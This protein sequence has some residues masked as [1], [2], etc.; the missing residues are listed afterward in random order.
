MARTY[1]IDIVFFHQPDVGKH[2]CAV[3]GMAFD[4]MVFLHVHSVY[5]YAASVDKQLRVANL[6]TS[7]TYVV[8]CR[9]DHIAVVVAQCQHKPVEVGR[10]GAPAAYVLDFVSEIQFSGS[11]FRGGIYSAAFGIVDCRIKFH[12]LSAFKVDIEIKHTVAVAVVE[13]RAGIEVGYA[14]A[15]V[16]RVEIHVAVYAREAPE[17]LVFE[18]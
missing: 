9:F 8:G 3:Y 1:G 7:E 11:C 2:G 5:F 15:A 17:V 10:F 12:P 6:D 18:I 4:R 14:A 16:G 13:S